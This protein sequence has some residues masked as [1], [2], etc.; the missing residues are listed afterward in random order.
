MSALSDGQAMLDD[1]LDALGDDGVLLRHALPAALREDERDLLAQAV[2]HV[3]TMSAAAMLMEVDPHAEARE[4]RIDALVAERAELRA[5]LAPFAAGGAP[6]SDLGIDG[7]PA[8]W[9]R[10]PTVGDVRRA[11]ALLGDEEE[12][13]DG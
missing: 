4:A 13:T 12:G 9:Q 8:R 5:A 6:P 1:A 10:E 11:A 7:W 3:A 2:H